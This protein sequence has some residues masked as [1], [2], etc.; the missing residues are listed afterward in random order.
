ME[1]R[2]LGQTA[3]M[4]PTVGV[5]TWRVFDVKDDA[6][7]ARCERVVTAALDAGAQLFDSSPMYG[8]AE[9]VLALSLGERRERAL[10]A[11]K[12]WARTRAIGEGQIE[13]ALAWFG[14]VELYQVH[15]LLALRDHLPLLQ[16]L[17]RDGR[18]DAIGA[19]HY[20]PAEM[21]AVAELVDAGAIEV[22]QVPYHPLERTVEDRLLPAAHARGVG[23]IAMMPF[24]TGRLLE[25]SPGTEALAPLVAF[26]VRTWPQALL[27][28]ALSDPRVHAAIPATS[29]PSHMVDNARA[30]SPPWFGPDERR[31]V[32]ELAERLA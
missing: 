16:S 12:V 25:R 13:R 28:W 21:A 1:R 2:Q 11:T 20:L 18:V 17:Q 23:V 6:G 5:G 29:S 10:V 27:K 9:R 24:G 15:N 14:R 7:E 3:L 8:E 22:V 30:G 19:T 26:G 32:R 31:Y 4:V